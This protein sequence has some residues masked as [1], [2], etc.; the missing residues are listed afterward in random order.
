VF[1][2]SEL[3]R[4]EKFK[5]ECALASQYY[6]TYN[7]NK[8]LSIRKENPEQN[9]EM[10]KT[11]G[12]FSRTKVPM[13]TMENGTQVYMCLGRMYTFREVSL[14]NEYRQ[15]SKYHIL[16]KEG[17]LNVQNSKTIDAFYFIESE[18]VKNEEIKRKK[19][20]ES[21]SSRTSR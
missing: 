10:R 7:C 18:I 11:K 1:R 8:C 13:T 6:E 16:P 2:V 5:L 20:G 21:N 9:Y 12:C 3:N 19:D 14:V 4:W 17:H 15:F